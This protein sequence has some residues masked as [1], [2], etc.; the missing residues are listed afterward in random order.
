MRA[1]GPWQ[2]PVQGRS[3]YGGMTTVSPPR[4]AWMLGRK[5]DPTPCFVD[6]NELNKRYKPIWILAEQTWKSLGS[7]R[8]GVVTLRS[9]WMLGWTFFAVRE[10]KLRLR[11][12]LGCLGGRPTLL[13]GLWI[14][15]SWIKDTNQFGSLWSRL[16][17][18]LSVRELDW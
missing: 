13:L 12:Q 6:L 9:A 15:M 17:I 10:L 14:R 18:V 2:H 8:A 16:G 1:Y 3:P 5:T 11:D 4:S 7:P